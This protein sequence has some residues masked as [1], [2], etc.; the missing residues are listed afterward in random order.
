MHIYGSTVSPFVQRVLMTARARGH[1]IAV[2]AP[3][4]GN[5][6]SAEFQA[7]SP[8]GRIPVLALDDGRHICESEAI[9]QYLDETLSGPPIMPAAPLDRAR[10]REIVAVGLGEFAAGLRPLMVHLIFRMGEAPDVIAAARGQSELGLKALDRLLDRAGTHAVGNTLTPADCALVPMLTLAELIDPVA[11]S[12][13]V[14]KSHAPVH[15]YWQR[16]AAD[17][18]AKRTIDEM[19]TGF[20]AMMA[21]NKAKA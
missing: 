1:E 6:R 12:M 19:R 17:R 15:A 7:I 4:G 8:T 3:L 11:G 5:M 2:Q 9:V 20:A 18:N 21:R 13:T 16:I 10:V 14:V